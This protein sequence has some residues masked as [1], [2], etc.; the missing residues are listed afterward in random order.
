MLV[1]E[2]A[3]VVPTPGVWID[4]SACCSDVSLV[5]VLNGMQCQM[6]GVHSSSKSGLITKL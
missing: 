2:L 1:V 3:Q 6:G 5:L 4:S